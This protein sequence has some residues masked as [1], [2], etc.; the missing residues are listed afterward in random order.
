MGDA[1]R[2][3]SLPERHMTSLSQR[4]PW[5]GY[6]LRWPEEGI[7]YIGGYADSPINFVDLWILG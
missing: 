2:R 7:A 5:D 4:S 6:E 1:R 3:R